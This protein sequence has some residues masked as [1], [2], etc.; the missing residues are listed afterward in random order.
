MKE[1]AE[2]SRRW[3]IF[4]GISQNL[5]KQFYYQKRTKSILKN[6]INEKFELF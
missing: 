6:E 4:V 1:N 2:F 5:V 3:Q